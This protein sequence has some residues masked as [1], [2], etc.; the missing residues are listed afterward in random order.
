ML[1]IELNTSRLESR[2]LVCLHLLA[3]VAVWQCDL[4]QSACLS[5]ILLL[6]VS[7]WSQ[8]RRTSRDQP[9]RLQSIHFAG[10]RVL[11][12]GAD[13]E[14]N[15]SLREV[16]SC[17][18]WWSLL[19]LETAEPGPGRL[20]LLARWRARR[21]VLLTN[22]SLRRRSFR[23]LR[24]FLRLN[25]WRATQALRGLPDDVAGVGLRMESRA[26]GSRS[27]KSSV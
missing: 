3:A 14:V 5:L 26:S 4:S 16:R 19:L 8:L 7:L 1:T 12:C 6:M 11:L 17:G 23:R 25:D 27:G 2:L 22:L 24:R 18:E 20:R 21:W 13:G 15:Y 10:G 9:P